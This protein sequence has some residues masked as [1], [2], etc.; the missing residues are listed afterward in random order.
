[1][2]LT[3]ILLISAMLAMAVTVTAAPKED[4]EDKEDKMGRD[5]DTSDPATKGNTKPPLGDFPC[6]DDSVCSSEGGGYQCYKGYCTGKEQVRVWELNNKSEFG[7]F[8]LCLIVPY[9]PL[10]G[11]HQWEYLVMRHQPFALV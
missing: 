11:T 5:P 6:S 10:R 8:G 3:S 7:S 4:K 9:H 1:M 2:K